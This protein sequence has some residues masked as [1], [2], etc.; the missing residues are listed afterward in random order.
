MLFDV[1]ALPFKNATDMGRILAIQIYFALV[2]GSHS[3]FHAPSPL[4]Y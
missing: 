2:I 1:Q 4:E 3:P